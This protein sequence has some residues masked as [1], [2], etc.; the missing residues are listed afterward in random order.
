MA[1]AGRELRSY[2]LA[3][4]GYVI[5]A[6]FLLITGFVFFFRV[7]GEGELTSLRSVFG[8][9]TWLL[10]VVAPAITMRLISEEYRLG[11]FE[12]LMTCPVREAE[13][14][15]GKFLGALALLVVML[16]PTWVYVLGLELFGRPDYGEVLCGYAGLLLAGAAYLASGILA[17]SFTGSQP[18]AFLIAL[19][20]WLTFGFGAKLLPPHLGDRGRS[21]VYAVDPDLRLNDFTIGLVDT[22]NVV[23][24]VT[25]TGLFLLAAIVSLQARRW[26]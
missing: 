15:M 1:I 22:S 8:I 10:A 7:F 16:A 11:T 19:F 21:I 18:V 17:S 25:L 4:G 2:L 20:F 5:I 14:V 3:P 9:G 13:V 23:Y 6:L 24:F 12:A 26:R